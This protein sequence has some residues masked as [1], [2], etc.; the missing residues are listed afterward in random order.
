MTN[1]HSWC[2]FLPDRKPEQKE[3]ILED[4]LTGPDGR[5]IYY[6][7][8]SVLKI[9]TDV[10][11]SR[12]HATR[13]GEWDPTV[14][15]IIDQGWDPLQAGAI[16][17]A[18]HGGDDF[19]WVGKGQGRTIAAQT[20]KV[21]SVLVIEMPFAEVKDVAMSSLVEALT[22]RPH[23][24][25]AKY[26]LGMTAQRP[27][28]H[29]MTDIAGRHTLLIGDTSGPGTVPVGTVRRLYQAK[30]VTYPDEGMVLDRVLYISDALYWPVRDQAA[31]KADVLQ[32]I[33]SF[34]RLEDAVEWTFT[35][36]QFAER[37]L[38][39]RDVEDWL[40]KAVGQ[41]GSKTAVRKAL[42]D[43]WRECW[44]K[45]RHSKIFPAFSWNEER[46]EKTV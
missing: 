10:Q 29:A 6:T 14:Q 26:Q 16:E 41:S 1:R 4:V 17:V 21:P 28:D 11:R 43:L 27:E 22:T 19:L 42:A 37:I 31:R 13:P 34:V 25:Y 3:T 33:T 7:D 23:N 24:P 2:R 38:G 39:A 35:P 9:D 15:G 46:W 36:E 30:T 20:L 40:K 5:I 32:A 45:S 44:N 12:K 8:P 18:R